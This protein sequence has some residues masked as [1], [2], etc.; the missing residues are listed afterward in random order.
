ML[1]FIYYSGNNKRKIIFKGEE[2]EGLGGMLE[3]GFMGY[4]GVLRGNVLFFIGGK[5]LF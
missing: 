3:M 1:L 4:E 2:E 5:L